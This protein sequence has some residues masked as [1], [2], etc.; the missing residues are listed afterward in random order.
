M[1][2]NLI[3]GK[4]KCK[5]LIGTRRKGIKLWLANNLNLLLPE[6]FKQ[7]ATQSFDELWNTLIESAISNPIDFPSYFS[8]HEI[9][10]L[11]LT[12]LRIQE[13]RE[14]VAEF[15]MRYGT[16]SRSSSKTWMEN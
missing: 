8:T 2:H 4:S 3:K 9:R 11:S 10:K 5:I 7:M 14:K 16:N 12:K 1:Y 13:I 15:S 6:K